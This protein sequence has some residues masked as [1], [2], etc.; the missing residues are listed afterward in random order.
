MN[1]M[2]PFYAFAVAAIAGGITPWLLPSD[3]FGYVLGTC[4]VGLVIFAS[5]AAH[6]AKS[7]ESDPFGVVWWFVI[8]TA[9]PTAKINDPEALAL[10]FL[11]LAYLVGFTI[12]AFGAVHA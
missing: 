11:I 1:K 12:G 3:W 4:I 8:G 5:L 7:K 9:R 6:S 10:F 2:R